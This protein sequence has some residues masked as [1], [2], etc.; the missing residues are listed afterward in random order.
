MSSPATLPLGQIVDV[1]IFVSPQAPA[2]PEFNQGLVIGTSTVIP[3]FGGLSPRI[4]KYFNVAEILSDG[5]NLNS[6]EYIA[7]SIYFSQS[8]APAILW[9]GRQDLTSLNT[10]TI[11]VAGA[12]YVA[13]DIVGVTQGGAS[14]GQVKI[15]T[16]PAGIPATVAVFQGGTGYAVAGPLATTGGTGAGLTLNVTVI[17]E[18]ALLAL[19]ECRVASLEWWSVASL[20]AVKADHEAI[21]AFV[22]TMTPPGCYFFTTSDADALSGAAGNVFAVLKAASYNRVFGQYATTQSGLFPNN[23]YAAIAAMG[24]AMGSNTGLANSAFTM[25]FKVETG[26]ATEPLTPTSIGVVEGEGGNLYLSYGNTY[27]LLEQGVVVNGQFFDEIINLDMISSAIQF[28][29]M[30]LLVS[31]PKIP[32]TDAGQTQLIHAVNQACDEAFVRGFLGPGVWKGVQIINLK[33]GDTLPRGYSAQSYPYSTQ[34]P[35]DR[36]ARKAMPIYVA[37]VEAGAVHS[38]VIGVYVQR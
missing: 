21:G 8:P 4:R 14:L 16:A 5:F 12:G 34:S 13:G 20:A 26:I 2:A 1:E 32:Q 7:A 3:S 17:G 23:I 29:I 35:S 33:T 10:V 24:I 38:I 27:S 37:I 25:K 11:A 36:Q 22:Q 9:L 19:Q 15:L 6:P 31:N 18:T 30:N 28:N